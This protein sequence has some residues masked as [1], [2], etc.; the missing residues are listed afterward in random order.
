L[1]STGL[2]VMDAVYFET[3]KADISLNSKP[4]LTMLAKMLTKYPKLKIEVDGHTDNI[5]SDAYNMDLSQARAQSVRNYMVS[6]EPS[7]DARLTARGYGESSPKADNRTAAGRKLNRRTELQVL[8]KDALHEYNEP[9]LSGT[10]STQHAGSA[11][12]A[13]RDTSNAPGT[14]TAPSGGIPSGSGAPAGAGMDSTR[15]DSTHPNW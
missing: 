9:V 2:L 4:Y 13:P 11:A 15:T 10:P 14:A 5:G 3:G 7:L 1:L 6:Q 12:S 8:N